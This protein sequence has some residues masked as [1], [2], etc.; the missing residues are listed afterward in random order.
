MDLYPMM[1]MV[2][3][4]LI[5]DTCVNIRIKKEEDF[6]QDIKYFVISIP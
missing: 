2:F 6:L 5:K 4:P 3:R 1:K